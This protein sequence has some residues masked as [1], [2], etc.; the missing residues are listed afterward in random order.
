MFNEEVFW[1][2][3]FVIGLYLQLGEF[4]LTNTSW[5]QDHLSWVLWTSWFIVIVLFIKYVNCKFSS[6]F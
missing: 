4:L 6:H 3:M 5:G 2:W 1:H